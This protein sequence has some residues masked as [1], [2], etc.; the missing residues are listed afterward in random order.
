MQSEL[1]TVLFCTHIPNGVIDLAD[2][3]T[4]FPVTLADSPINQ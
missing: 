3:S 1:G 2:C 4:A